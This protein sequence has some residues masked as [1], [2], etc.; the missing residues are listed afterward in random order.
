MC[1]DRAAHTIIIVT[2]VTGRSIGFDGGHFGTDGATIRTIK[3]IGQKTDGR[4]D[5]DYEEVGRSGENEKSA[6]RT[7]AAKA[8][9][10]AK[11]E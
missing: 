11:R 5:G 2:A 3:R 4:V 10:A 1:D 6:G 7:H 9:A 8:T